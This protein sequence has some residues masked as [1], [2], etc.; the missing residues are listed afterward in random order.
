MNKGLPQ[1]AELEVVESTMLVV[2]VMVTMVFVV[3]VGMVFVFTALLAVGVDGLMMDSRTWLLD[4][5]GVHFGGRMGFDERKT[6][7]LPETVRELDRLVARPAAGAV[8][9]DWLDQTHVGTQDSYGTSVG[10]MVD[11]SI[12]NGR[13]YIRS[14]NRNAEGAG[15]HSGCRDDLSAVVAQGM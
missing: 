12:W 8:D 3:F 11:L 10:G 14:Y 7:Q 15:V 5:R 9:A 2:V 1:T 4:K 6:K 13:R